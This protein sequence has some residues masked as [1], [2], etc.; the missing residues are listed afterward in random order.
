MAEP[1]EL[2]EIARTVMP[3]ITGGVG[4]ATLTYL[5]VNAA[6]PQSIVGIAF[7]LRYPKRQS[8]LFPDG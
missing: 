7:M 5:S 6:C 4:V 3:W 8:L 1:N 2:L